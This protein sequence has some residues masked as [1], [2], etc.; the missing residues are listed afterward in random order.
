[1]PDG[2][3]RMTIHT[4]RRR[5]RP[6]GKPWPQPSRKMMLDAAKRDARQAAYGSGQSADLFPSDCGSHP[7]PFARW[8]CILAR[9]QHELTAAAELR[10]QGFATFVP[11]QLRWR[12]HGPHTRPV[13]VLA[14]PRY[15][16]VRFDAAADPWLPILHTRGVQRLLSITP[17]R[18]APVR[19]GVIEAIAAEMEA[20]LGKPDP[21]LALAPG[22]RGHVAAGPLS[23]FPATVAAVR[24]DGTLSVSITLFGRASTLTL[25]PGQFVPEAPPP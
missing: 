24:P 23:A 25:E 3:L 15:L 13:A 14:V 7:A 17:D 21:T 9:P 10:R 8:H 4:P 2:G 22:A 16:F 6:P 18:P 5:G 1:M 11:M 12:G 20:A 19:R